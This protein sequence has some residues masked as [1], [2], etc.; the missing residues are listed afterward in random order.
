MFEILSK[1]VDLIL[2]L[3]SEKKTARKEMFEQVF[4][5]M[6]EDFILV[7]SDYMDMFEGV[8]ALLN[9]N[10][11]HTKTSFRSGK[12]DPEDIQSSIVLLRENRKKLEPLRARLHG[13]YDKDQ[14]LK[15]PPEE[16]KFIWAVVEYFPSGNLRKH[17]SGGLSLIRDL[18]SAREHRDFDIRNAVG[19]VID[20]QKRRWENVCRSYAR[21]RLSLYTT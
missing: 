7:H 5:P 6:F 1:A 3:K 4:K 19:D 21:L 18:E 15:L 14:F 10:D 12:A 17:M 9:K 2:S 11:V 16:Q 20:S 8:D 13:S